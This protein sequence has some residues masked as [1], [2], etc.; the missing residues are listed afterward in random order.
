MLKVFLQQIFFPK[1]FKTFKV[2]QLIL[3][4]SSFFIIL[5]SKGK[6]KGILIINAVQFELSLI[7]SADQGI[8]E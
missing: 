4:G 6:I 5:V 7:G 2:F 3:S 8:D 1:L